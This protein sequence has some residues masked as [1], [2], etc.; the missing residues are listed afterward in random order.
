MSL[1]LYETFDKDDTVT[2]LA[3]FNVM[4]GL[5]MSSLTFSEHIGHRFA[6]KYT[7]VFADEIYKNPLNP[8]LNEEE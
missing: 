7:Y 5:M 1:V 8:D 3:M 2:F 4:F 6:A